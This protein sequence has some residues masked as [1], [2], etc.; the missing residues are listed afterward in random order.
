MVFHSRFAWIF[1]VAVSALLGCSAAGSDD[2]FQR[3][4]AGFAGDGGS[5][6]EEEFGGAGGSAAA[7]KGGGGQGG[8]GHAGGGAGGAAGSGVGGSA[9]GAQGGSSQGGSSQGGSS[10]GGSAGTGG[11]AACYAEIYDPDVSIDDLKSAYSGGNWLNISLQVLKR[12]YPTGWFVLDAEKNDPQLQGFV[13]TGSWG[14]FVMSLDTMVHEETHGWDFDHSSYGSH[15]YVLR[16]DLQLQVPESATWPRSD[17]LQ[18]I[19][20][21]TTQMY[22]DVYLTGEQ[23]TYDAI[24]LMDEVNAYA[25]GLATLTSVHEHVPPSISSR[26]GAAAMTLYLELYLKAGRTSHPAQYASMKADASWQKLV[27]YEWARVHFWESEAKPFANLSIDADAIWAKINLP[28][29][30]DEI[31]QFTGQDPASVACTP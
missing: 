21:G 27:R 31:E 15:K 3:G 4:S 16:D 5:G 13:D 18:Y 12:R 10:Q 26:D 22:D 23:G 8:T 24:F 30:L 19:N 6:G 14:S 7:G 28:A 20:D 29:N 9:A 25:N 2:L 17:I 1:F 11:T